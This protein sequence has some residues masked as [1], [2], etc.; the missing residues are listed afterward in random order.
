MCLLMMVVFSINLRKL[1][2]KELA[3]KRCNKI[4]L[5][6]GEKMRKP[7]K[8]LGKETG[9]DMKKIGIGIADEIV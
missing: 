4:N 3:N 2:I 8:L 5:K 9:T 7:M 6:I 1:Q